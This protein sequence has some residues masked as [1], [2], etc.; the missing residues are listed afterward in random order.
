MSVGNIYYAVITTSFSLKKAGDEIGEATMNIDIGATGI[1]YATLEEATAG[2]CLETEL[3]DTKSITA[4]IKLPEQINQEKNYTFIVELMPLNQGQATVDVSVSGEETYFYG[5]KVNVKSNVSVIGDVSSASSLEYRLFNDGKYGP[6]YGGQYYTVVG[7][8]QSRNTLIYVPTMY[9]GLPVKEIGD[10]AFYGYNAL[11]KLTISEGIVKIG[12]QAIAGCNNLFDIS[13]PTTLTDVDPTAFEGASPSSA[14]AALAQIAYIPK[15]SLKSIFVTGGGNITAETFA[16]CKKLRTITAL[17]QNLTAD[18]DAFDG[19]NI[20][21]A[22][23]HANFI[24]YLPKTTVMFVNVNAGTSIAEKEFE[25]FSTLLQANIYDGITEIGLDAFKDCGRLCVIKYYGPAKIE[26][27][28]FYYVNPIGHVLSRKGEFVYLQ[29]TTDRKIVAYVGE[30]VNVTVP[31]ETVELSSYVFANNKYIKS[32]Y[33]PAKITALGSNLFSGCDSLETVVIDDNSAVSNIDSTFH[34]CSGLKH[35]QLPRCVDEIST[36]LLEGTN[37]VETI[38]VSPNN[39]AFRAEGNCII[40][41]TTERVVLGCKESVIPTSSDVKG[42]EAGFITGN[43][44]ITSIFIPANIEY[45]CSTAFLRCKE[46]VSIEV[47]PNNQY[48]EVVN[49]CLI[50]KA[51]KKLVMGC[52]TSIIPAEYGITEIMAN[53]FRETDITQIVIPEGV[54]TIGGSAFYSCKELTI[55]TLPDTLKLIEAY[56]FEQCGKLTSITL[57]DSIKKI[58]NGAFKSCEELTSI[59][60]PAGLEEIG[61]EAFSKDKK[62]NNIRIPNTVKQIEQNAFS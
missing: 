43:P 2:D 9:E 27:Y 24:E 57:P 23:I 56:A 38:T 55:V 47:D 15:E 49:N 33:I 34:N 14:S 28:S 12:A 60:F 39:M 46:L 4:T 30:R 25:G 36:Y 48:Y 61:Y 41:K 10:G 54:E 13:L 19:L 1:L 53:A 7:L 20:I 22:T 29:T 40:N 17:D 51:T 52:K 32:V 45:V 26:G 42:I 50:E 8:G 62:L 35:F 6:E 58:D 21:T 44:N 18:T 37:N 16:G 5:D 3:N 59:N 31:N 11:R